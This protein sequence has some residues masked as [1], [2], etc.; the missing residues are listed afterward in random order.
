MS[1]INTGFRE[2]QRSK[3]GNPQSPSALRTAAHFRLGKTHCV[4][5]FDFNKTL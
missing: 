1:V 4:F 2:T 5:C 3:L